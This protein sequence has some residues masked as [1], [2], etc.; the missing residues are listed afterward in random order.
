MSNTDQHHGELGDL[1]AGVSQTINDTRDI[2]NPKC[3]HS[4]HLSRLYQSGMD[5]ESGG[6]S[7]TYFGQ[8]RIGP[9]AGKNTVERSHLRAG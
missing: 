5:S 6:T 1:F 3:P 2:S 4:L 9:N 8:Q 7:G